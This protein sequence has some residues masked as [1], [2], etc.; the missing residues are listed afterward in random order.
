MRSLLRSTAVR[1]AFGYA[2]LFIVS[3]LLLAGFLWWRTAI[4]LDR[5]IDAVIIADGQ[6]IADRLRDFGLPGAIDTI[7]ERVGRA[8]DQRAIYLLTDPMLTPLAGNLQAWP[9]AVRSA[10]GWYQIN[11]VRDGNLQ[12]TRVLFLQLPSGFRLLVGRDVEDRVE[13]RE[14]IVSAL[15][16]SSLG[17]LILAIAGGLLVRGAVLRRVEAINRTATRD[18]AGRS[19]A[20][21]PDAR[22]VRRIRPAGAD[23]QHHAGT[24]RTSDR[25]RAQRNQCRRARPAHAA[26]RV[27]DAAGNADRHPAAAGRDL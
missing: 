8:S 13:V 25:G 5:E 11:L 23:D 26:C 21:G 18:R 15:G 10:P 2:V 24:N 20:S 14:L 9:L 19:F 3:S 17:A 16:W 6:A 4:Y 27:A 1:L 22:I 12:M 7:S